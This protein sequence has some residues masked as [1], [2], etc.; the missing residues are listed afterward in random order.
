[1]TNMHYM[2]INGSTRLFSIN[3]FIFILELLKKKKIRKTEPVLFY[4]I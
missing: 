4:K 1:M 3:K 2:K